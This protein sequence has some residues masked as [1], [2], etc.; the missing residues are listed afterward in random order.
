MLPSHPSFKVHLGTFPCPPYHT[1]GQEKPLPAES[2]CP[3]SDFWPPQALLFA[4]LLCPDPT[5]G[6]S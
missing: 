3:C 5:E 2:H 4:L 6:L 1:P